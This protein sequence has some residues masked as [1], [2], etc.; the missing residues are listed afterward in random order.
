MEVTTNPWFTGRGV[1]PSMLTMFAMF[2][3]FWVV[4]QFEKRLFSRSCGTDYA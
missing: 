3:N 2:F 1:T 4:V